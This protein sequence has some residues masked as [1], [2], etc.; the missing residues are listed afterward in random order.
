MRCLKYDG[1]E[2]YDPSVESEQCAWC[3]YQ[4]NEDKDMIGRIRE[5]GGELRVEIP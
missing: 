3:G 5:A 1:K 4:S 2:N